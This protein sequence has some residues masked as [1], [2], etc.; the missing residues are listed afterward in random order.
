VSL[1]VFCFDRGGRR[2]E[3]A[4][5]CR[6]VGVPVT[7][8]PDR[9]PADTTLPSQLRRALVRSAVDVVQTH[10]YRASVLFRLARR[11]GWRLPWIAFH[12]GSTS[13]HWR[14]HAYLWLEW[15]ATRAA[16]VL[17]VMS[18]VQARAFSGHRDV[19]RILNA[20]IASDTI[21]ASSPVAVA[22]LASL[23][24]PVAGVFA[25][26]SPEKGVDVLL[27]ALARLSK[28]GSPM[29]ALVAGDGPQ[30]ALLEARVRD[31]GLQH[32]VAFVGHLESLTLSTHW[33]TS[34][35]CRRGAKG[36]PTCC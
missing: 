13:E 36:F 20:V 22:A 3:F 4:E 24:R 32:R 34:L 2:H 19:R 23:P 15:L 10:G 30:R 35:Y 31:L 29:S 26:L 9:G 21:P 12:H 6:V 5:A 17:V 28:R 7:L 33:S 25:R 14:M 1:E 11:P 27:E 8:L 18:E 16:D